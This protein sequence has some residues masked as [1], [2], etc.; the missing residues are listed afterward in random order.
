[1]AVHYGL[2]RDDALIGVPYAYRDTRGARGV[3]RVHAEV[4][5]TE[6]Y[7]RNGLQF[8]PFNTLYQL[9]SEAPPGLGANRLLMIPD[10]LTYWLSGRRSTRS[11]TPHRPAC[12]TRAPAPGT[13]I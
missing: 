10:L 4:P 8:L 7:R 3:A 12:S 6:L 13:P 11:P 1:M 2:L 9:S 5:F